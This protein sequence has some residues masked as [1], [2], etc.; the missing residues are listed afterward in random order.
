MIM[1]HNWESAARV[2]YYV[3]EEGNRKQKAISAF[4]I[5]LSYE[6]RGDFDEAAA[7]AD[8]SRALFQDLGSLSASSLDVDRAERYYNELKDRIKEAEKLQEQVGLGL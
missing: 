2:W 3:F 6:I 4:N 7:W 8:K 1:A 5:A